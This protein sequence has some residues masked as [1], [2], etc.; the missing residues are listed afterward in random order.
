[1]EKSKIDFLASISIPNQIDFSNILKNS[2]YGMAAR[3]QVAG[4][5]GSALGR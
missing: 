4:T 1:M 5:V 2:T 3:Q